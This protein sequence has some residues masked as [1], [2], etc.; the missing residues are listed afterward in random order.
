MSD[1]NFRVLSNI[2]KKVKIFEYLIC[3]LMFV[4]LTDRLMKS[5]RLHN[6]P[7]NLSNYSN[8]KVK[9]ILFINYI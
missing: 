2:K 6:M 5:A 9:L 3:R 7:A 4:Q 8:N 1:V